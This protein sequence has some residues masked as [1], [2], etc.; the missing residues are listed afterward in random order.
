MDIIKTTDIQK[1]LLDITGEIVKLTDIYAAAHK[2]KLKPVRISMAYIYTPEQ[3]AAII[4][5]LTNSI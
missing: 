4:D 5:F 3:K 1:E 2:L